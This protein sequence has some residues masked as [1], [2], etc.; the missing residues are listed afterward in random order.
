ML[1]PTGKAHPRRALCV[2]SGI[3]TD[4]LDGRGEMNPAAC[5]FN[6]SSHRLDQRDVAADDMAGALF[7]AGTLPS[8]LDTHEARPNPGCR[9]VVKAAVK[10]CLQH[11]APDVV[12]GCPPA[13]LEQP[14][15]N[16]YA[17]Q[18]TPI[19]HPLCCQYGQP[20]AEAIDPAERWKL[21]KLD[22]VVHRVDLAI[23]V[24][25]GARLVEAHLV[26]NPQ[27]CTQLVQLGIAGEDGMVE[28]IDIGAVRQ[29]QRAGK[30]AQC[31]RCFID[32]DF[33][34][35]FRQVIG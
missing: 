23:M 25:A 30:P 8:R 31:G 29:R 6:T 1:D 15:L 19:P 12:I 4:F 9:Y 11:G 13:Q 27:F 2:R 22:N 16:T 34:G 7:L 14:L 28:A 10:L 17:L 18:V 26:G 5:R 35:L 33:D 20:K 21:Q 3:D 32:V 24:E